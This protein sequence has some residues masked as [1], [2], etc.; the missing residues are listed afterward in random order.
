MVMYY[1]TLSI[2]SIRLGFRPLEKCVQEVVHFPDQPDL[3]HPLRHPVYLHFRLHRGRILSSLRSIL[4]EPQNRLESSPLA[5]MAVVAAEYAV[6]RVVGEG[7]L[8]ASL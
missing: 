7:R 5:V 2:G 6:I 4:L 1:R 3:R 8:A